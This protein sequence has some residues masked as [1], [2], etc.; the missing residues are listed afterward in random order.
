[1]FTSC[2]KDEMQAP[3][4]HYKNTRDLSNIVNPTEAPTPVTMSSRDTTPGSRFLTEFTISA[5]KIKI[6][7]AEHK[8]EW[9]K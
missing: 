4:I 9:P 5:E 1:M 6:G 7:N 3:A 2:S 8:N